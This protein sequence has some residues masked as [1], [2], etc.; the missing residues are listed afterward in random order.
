MLSTSDSCFLQK[1]HSAVDGYKTHLEVMCIKPPSP[2]ERVC[3]GED[4]GFLSTEA[5]C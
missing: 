5:D 2:P 4:N 1:C 3:L